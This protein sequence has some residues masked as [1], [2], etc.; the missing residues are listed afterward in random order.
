MAIFVETEQFKQMIA[1]NPV[2]T[3]KSEKK[4]VKYELLEQIKNVVGDK[5]TRFKEGTR[6]TFDMMC[7]LSAELGFVY[8]SDEYLADR[9]DISDRTLRNRF[10]ELEELGQ[11]VK[12]YRRAKR[13]NGRGKPIY[14]FVNHPYFKYWVELLGIKLEDFQIDFQTENGGIAC[15]SKVE[16]EKKVPTYYLPLKQE[17]NNIYISNDKIVQFVVNRVQDSVNKGTKIKFL[18]SYID[19]VVRSLENQAMY[20]E[21]ARDIARR[22]KHQ[23]KNSN[24]IQDLLGIQPNKSAIYNWLKN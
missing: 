10:K 20:W 19:H 12:V 16:G 8:A 17:N 3:T 14:L 24:M 6:Q 21:N 11:V 23:E 4:K 5:W 7:F 22:K 1:F 15:E 2:A 18:S 9:H 13:C